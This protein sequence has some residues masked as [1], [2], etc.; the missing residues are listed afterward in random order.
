MVQISYRTI[1]KLHLQIREKK[2]F[3]IFCFKI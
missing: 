3:N 1:P 2:K